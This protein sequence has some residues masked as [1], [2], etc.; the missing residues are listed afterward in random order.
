MRLFFFFTKS[1]V[2]MD[3]RT[4]SPLPDGRANARRAAMAEAPDREPDAMDME[5]TG[6]DGAHD[7]RW[8]AACGVRRAVRCDGRTDG[9]AT[10]PL[11]VT[12]AEGSG[13][14]SGCPLGTSDAMAHGM[15]GIWR[16]E[17]LN[18]LCTPFFYIYTHESLF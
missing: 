2:I 15:D 7:V 16:N 5:E 3:G 12:R 6:S 13:P 9:V 1:F 11:A 8:V 18:T 4:R 10:P 17:V 14:P